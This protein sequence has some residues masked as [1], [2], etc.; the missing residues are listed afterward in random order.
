MASPDWEIWIKLV[1]QNMSK[2]CKTELI[3]VQ[4]TYDVYLD[5]E[6]EFELNL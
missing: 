5:Y 6:E 1:K 3:S 4:L 2:W